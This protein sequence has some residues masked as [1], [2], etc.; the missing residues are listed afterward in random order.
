MFLL[1]PPHSMEH[2]LL[3]E[4][5]AMRTAAKCGTRTFGQSGLSFSGRWSQCNNKNSWA[6]YILWRHKGGILNAKRVNLWNDSCKAS[7]SVPS[8]HRF[9]VIANR[10]FTKG[11]AAIKLTAVKPIFTKAGPSLTAGPTEEQWLQV[12]GLVDPGA[13]PGSLCRVVRKYRGLLA[14]A[15]SDAVSWLNNVKHLKAGSIY[16]FN[17]LYVLK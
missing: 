9:E 8:L 4:Q 13:G 1:L 5:P 6:K 17:A 15:G 2:F 7:T 12:E 10:Q 3:A 14:T 16:M 11:L